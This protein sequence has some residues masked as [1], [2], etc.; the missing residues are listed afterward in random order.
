VLARAALATG[1]APPIRRVV[2]ISPPN[3]G[4]RMAEKWRRY[5]PVHRAGWDPLAQFRPGACSV[6]PSPPAEVGV[7]AGG[8][9]HA[10]GMNRW[11]GA[12]ND[13]TV[14]VDE[15]ALEG[16][17]DFLVIP[18]QHS[19]MLLSPRAVA[20]VTTFLETGRFSR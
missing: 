10:R 9:G 8:L 15:A 11:L 13:G 4:A 7:L 20:Q 14:R 2:M 6:Y 12:D 17:A 18:V 1:Q 16:A 3:Q 5:L 19:W